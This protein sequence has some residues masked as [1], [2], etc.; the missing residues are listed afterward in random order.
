MRHYKIYSVILLLTI[1]SLLFTGCNK[2][3]LK[4]DN[5]PNISNENEN[6]NEDK[7]ENESDNKKD[8]EK[9]DVKLELGDKARISNEDIL[10]F[11]DGDIEMLSYI[12]EYVGKSAPDI[13]LID[14]EGNEVK[15]SDFIGNN[16]II[17]F[18]GT[19]CSACAKTSETVEEFNGTYKN[20]KIIPIAIGANIEDVKKF[21]EERSL[22]SKYYLPKDEDVLNDLYKIAFVPT[23]F[24]IDSEGYVQ[25]ILGGSLP[26]DIL[27]NFA[28]NAFEQK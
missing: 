27:N 3:N 10:R 6:D 25:M 16:M 17:E 15:L 7:N 11:Y 1:I 2:Q 14:L 20:A 13:E 19:W 8:D 22:N 28:N 23:F 12:N 5:L 21:K 24:Y 4:V 18:M 26:L 9:I